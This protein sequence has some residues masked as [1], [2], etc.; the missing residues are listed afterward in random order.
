MQHQFDVCW[1]FGRKF[2]PPEREDRDH[3][4]LFEGFVTTARGHTHT[5]PRSTNISAVLWQWIF[6]S[7]GFP[8][9]CELRLD[10]IPLILLWNILCTFPFA[11]V[12]DG[13]S[14]SKKLCLGKIGKFASTSVR[15]K[16]QIIQLWLLFEALITANEGNKNHL[17]LNSRTFSLFGVSVPCFFLSSQNGNGGMP[18]NRLQNTMVQT[19]NLSGWKLPLFTTKQIQLIS[20]LFPFVFRC[21]PQR[22]AGSWSGNSQREMKNQPQLSCKMIPSS[23]CQCGDER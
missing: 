7:F 15:L 1:H 23:R 3:F 9:L 14:Q 18:G 13:W 20:F 19:T 2:L 21:W 8:L 4:W 11:C 16:V 22:G 17:W 12:Q 6:N 5:Y 10:H